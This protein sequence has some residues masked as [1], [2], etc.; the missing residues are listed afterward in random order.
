[1]TGAVFTTAPLFHVQLFLALLDL[2][3][4][5]FCQLLGRAPLALS[6]AIAVRRVCKHHNF[7][8][9]V[10]IEIL[11]ISPERASRMNNILAQPA[12]FESALPKMM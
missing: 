8:L 3:S 1:V 7:G 5:V 12:L 4:A 11:A 9:S 10:T 6:G 2:L